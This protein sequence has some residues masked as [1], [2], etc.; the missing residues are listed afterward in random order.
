[1]KNRFDP[2]II[3]VSTRE[4]WKVLDK[5]FWGI[6]EDALKSAG[7]LSEHERREIDPERYTILYRAYETLKGFAGKDDQAR[8]KLHPRFLSGGA[9][10]QTCGITLQ[11]EEIKALK[12]IIEECATFGVEPLVNG[13]VDVGVSVEH[14]FKQNQDE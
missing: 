10:L 13:K 14:F 3:G 1:M 11:E 6:F 2:V 7:E 4:E 5:E 9:T 12:D 8:I